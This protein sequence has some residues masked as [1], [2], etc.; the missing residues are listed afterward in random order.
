MKYLLLVCALATC[1]AGCLNP[2]ENNTSEVIGNDEIIAE[3]DAE[4]Y[5]NPEETENEEEFIEEDE[6]EVEVDYTEDADY[7]LNQIDIFFE[8]LSTGDIDTLVSMCDEEQEYYEYLVA[9][10]EYDFTPAFLQALY[11]DTKYYVAEDAKEYLIDDLESFYEDGDDDYIS[12]D[13]VFSYRYL[14]LMSTVYPSAFEDGTFIEEDREYGSNDEAIAE[15][16]KIVPLVPCKSS[17]DFYIKI[18]E[19]GKVLIAADSIL[20]NMEIEEIGE[21]N[22]KYPMHYAEEFLEVD[23]DMI[24]GE[25]G[26]GFYENNEALVEIDRLL[27]AKDFAGLEEYLGSVTGEDYRTEYSEKYGSYEELTDTQKAFVDDFISNNFEYQLIDYV[28]AEDGNL[29]NY[30]GA[31]FILSY[32]ML[33]QTDPVLTQWY[34]DNDI[35]D[36]AV[37]YSL[38]TKLPLF[39]DF[40]WRYYA[41]I[42]YAKEYIE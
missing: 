37:S 28:H 25:S 7:V 32:P 38:S 12:V 26:N 30:R 18:T 11:G 5:D 23:S 31:A 24:A 39:D 29:Y 40:I 13:V 17:Q 41:V 14:F 19:D 33:D 10:S 34:W 36:L 8:A 35:K 1:L 4:E 3:N 15:L 27:A 2:T 9:M 42:Q 16:A 20:E 21:I 6:E 22:E